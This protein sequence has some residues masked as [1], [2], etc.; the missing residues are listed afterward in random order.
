MCV[1]I[2]RTA[3]KFILCR[4]QEPKICWN[5]V[6][7]VNFWIQCGRECFIWMDD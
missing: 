6:C 7:R 1:L 3:V 4:A 2:A 5:A